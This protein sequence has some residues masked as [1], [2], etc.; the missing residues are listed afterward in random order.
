M[1]IGRD[2]PIFA[3]TLAAHGVPFEMVETL[4]AAV[5]AAFAAANTIMRP[6]CCCPGHRQLGPVQKL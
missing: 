5:P 6:S 1:L 2:A 3:E 4:D